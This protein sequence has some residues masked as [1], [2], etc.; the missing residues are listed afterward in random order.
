MKNRKMKYLSNVKVGQK[1]KLWPYS[2]NEYRITKVNRNGR[3]M[4]Q[5]IAPSFERDK[6]FVCSTKDI[7]VWLQADGWCYNGGHE[8]DPM[9]LLE[10][11][12]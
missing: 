7:Y 12:G 5:E 10:R 3:V 9:I 2:H 8:N 11:L 4:V 1:V 6:P